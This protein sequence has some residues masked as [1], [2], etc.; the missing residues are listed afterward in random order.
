MTKAVGR[1]SI[2]CPHDKRRTRCKD[3][4]GGSICIHGKQRATCKD[5]GGSQICIHGK[6]RATCKDC[7]GSQICIHGKHRAICKD[8]GGSKICIHGKQRPICKD[9]GGGSICIHGKHRATCKDCGGSQICI[10]G[11]R[12]ARCKDC[13]GGSI[14]I[15]G[16]QRAR[17]KDCGGGS[18][19]IH[20]KQRATCKD[21][22]GSQICIHGKHRAIC[23][24][25]GGSQICLHGKQ[26]PRCK[27]CGGSQ[28]CKSHSTTM[29][30]T[31]GSR[32]YRGHC[33]RCFSH[34]FPDEKISKN[35]RIKER[36][37]VDFIR[38]AFPNLNCV[39]DQSVE[40]GCSRRRPDI[41]VDMGT[42]NLVIEVD[43]NQHINYSCEE[44]RMMQIFLDG[45]SI[46]LVLIRF[47]PDEYMD[48]QGQ[49]WSSCFGLDSKGISRVRPSKRDEWASRLAAL[50]TTITNVVAIDV[51]TREV[52]IHMLF[53]DDRSQVSTLP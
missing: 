35:Y 3:C 46:P 26:R 17:C 50:T 38:K 9:C 6:Q 36:V 39:L 23:K 51:P 21:C 49:R 52:T 12:R 1:A 45:G 44:K 24:D 20:G 47:N 5:C 4:G 8:C 19:C 7:G 18:I 29:C 11:K 22:G 16:K 30:G 28:I 31:I 53:Y 43:E 33:V 2:K 34:L 14:C 32:K 42:Y 25:C 10:H 13:G 27:D 40:G 41:Y 37:V 48:A 15:H